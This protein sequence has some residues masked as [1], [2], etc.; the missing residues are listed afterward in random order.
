MDKL[1]DI[2][3]SDKIIQ[4]LSDSYQEYPYPGGL[5]KDASRR[6]NILP[7]MWREELKRIAKVVDISTDS[8]D[9]KGVAIWCKL[10]DLKETSPVTLSQILSLFPFRTKITELYRTALASNDIEHNRDA[11]GMP[12]NTEYLYILGVSPDAQHQGIGSKLVLERMKVTDE[13]GRGMYLET[14]T[15][16]NVRFYKR[17]GFTVLK[18]YHNPKTG[19]TTWFMYHTPPKNN[20]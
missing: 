6:K 9:A 10:K 13:E 7:I 16:H 2:F 15:E 18:E 14:N 8:S 5:I 17:L 3:Q 11:L 20:I 19:I 4:T 12:D 1:K